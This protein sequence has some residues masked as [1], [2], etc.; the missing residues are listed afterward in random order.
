MQNKPRS[1]SH[2]AATLGWLRENPAN[3]AAL[4]D[5]ARETGDAGDIAA[6]LGLIADAR[7]P[8]VKGRD[9]DS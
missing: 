2:R 9:R 1:D 7:L 5:A 4:L 8:S 3:C 6:A